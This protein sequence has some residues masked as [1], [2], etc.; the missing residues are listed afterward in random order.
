VFEPI[1]RDAYDRLAAQA[2]AGLW[3]PAPDAQQAAAS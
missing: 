3:V 2:A 1:G